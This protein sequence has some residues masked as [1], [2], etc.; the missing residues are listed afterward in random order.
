MAEKLLLV[1]DEAEAL[2][3]LRKLLEGARIGSAPALALN[4][5]LSLQEH[6]ADAKFHAEELNKP[7]SVG[8][9]VA[10]LT[11]AIINARISDRVGSIPGYG[12]M[13]D[14]VS[15]HLD[16]LQNKPNQGRVENILRD[17]IRNLPPQDQ[18]AE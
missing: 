5:V 13:L 17:I 3:E 9:Q 12:L 8:A 2:S 6:I 1:E 10:M 4:D 16:K 11:A 15:F 14:K 7:D 18:R